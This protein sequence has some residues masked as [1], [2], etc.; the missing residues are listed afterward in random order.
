MDRTP[1]EEAENFI[2]NETQFHLG[3]L[4]TEQSHPKTR[5][6]SDLLRGDTR[7][8]LDMLLGVDDDLPPVIE[9]VLASAPF[10]KL[11]ADMEQVL[12]SQGRIHFSGCGATGRLAIL[13]DSAHRHFWENAAAANPDLASLKEEFIQKTNAVMTGGDFALIRSVESFEDFISFGCNQIKEAGLKPGDMTVAISEGGETS[14]VIG[15]I[16]ASLEIGVPVSFLFNNPADL[17]AEHVDRSRKVI[18]DPRVNVLDLTTGSMSVAGSTRMQA[19]TMELI[20]AGIAFETALVSVLKKRLGADALKKIGFDGF[21]PA[22]TAGLFNTMLKQLRTPEN[23]DA[24]AA[25]TDFE[26]DIYKRR[27][28]ITYFAD[29]YLLDIFTDTTERAPT[30]KTPPFH[31]CQDQNAPDP[32]AFV[33]DP[34]R[35]TRA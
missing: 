29:D 2:A 24:L 8:G 32:W 27:G 14:S 16:H 18:T 12:W 30:F 3:Y 31:S 34:C 22:R 13:I 28:K 10:Q 5:G 11:V 25:Y 21:D 19:T 7:A 1:L 33:K 6:L 17:L 35:K 23:L 9:K 4:V 20:V 26:A 15:T